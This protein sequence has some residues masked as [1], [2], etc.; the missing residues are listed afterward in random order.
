MATK[1]T[2]R[3]SP[4]KGVK[5]P[6]GGGKK[7]ARPR[8]KPSK[9]KPVKAKKPASN[10][11]PKTAPKAKPKPAAKKLLPP[12][13]ASA[14][15][16]PL[17]DAV[18]GGLVPKPPRAALPI[19]PPTILPPKPIEQEPPPS[20]SYDRAAAL[21]TLADLVK[22]FERH[23]W[24]EA[25]KKSAALPRLFP[26]FIEGVH[27]AGFIRSISQRQL[28]RPE[29]PKSADDFELAATEHLNQG[30]GEGALKLLG[31]GLRKHPKHAGLWYLDACAHVQTG[32]LE[33]ALASL[34]KAIALD[35]QNRIYALNGKDFA[36]L[37]NH[38]EFVALVKS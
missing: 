31:G 34:G 30:D 36:P 14:I 19:P 12:R 8:A 38:A 17:P 33:A 21:K 25:F 9:A 20:Y 6:G 11:R 23:D 3:K 24:R 7:P 32:A 22:S 5:K 15:P 26:D 13:T 27:K 28:G 35:P 29:Q 37:K 1:K 16:P 4:G 10:A 2:G 18:Y